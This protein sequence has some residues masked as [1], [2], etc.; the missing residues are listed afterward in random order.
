MNIHCLQHVPFEELGSIEPILR[1]NGHR[2]SSTHL[3]RGDELP[4]VADLAW[5]I[6][7]GGPMGTYDD[8]MYGW[9]SSEKQFIE[10]VIKAGKKY[11]VSA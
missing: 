11:S 6:V 7:M 3:Y 2:L 9:L 5:L 1:E 10:Q 4:D 8:H